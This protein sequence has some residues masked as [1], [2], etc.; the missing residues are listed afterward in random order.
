MNY[1]KNQH[2]LNASS[3]L[4]GICFVIITAIKVTHLNEKTLADD[5]SLVSAIAMMSATL[6]AYIS[7][8]VETHSLV[9]ERWADRAFLVGL[10][11][12]L[13]AAATFYAGF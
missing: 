4:L 3:N 7:M 9:C 5:I 12:L 11:L 2:I 8:R 6:M 10:F 1:G 13:V